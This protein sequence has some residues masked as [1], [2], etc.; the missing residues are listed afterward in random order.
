MAIA[1]TCVIVGAQASAESR[2]SHPSGGQTRVFRLT[3]SGQESVGY[4]D[5]SHQDA[6][7]CEWSE[8]GN[9][10]VYWRSSWTVTAEVYP[11]TGHVQIKDVKVLKGPD[12]NRHPGDGEAIGKRS[13]IPGSHPFC[14]Q[15]GY[16]GTYK[17]TS[18][19]VEPALFL[20]KPTFEPR[21]GGYD[22]SIPGFTFA[23]AT[24][25]G[26]APTNYPCGEHIGTDVAPGGGASGLIGGSNVEARSS[27]G[28]STLL[29][30][31]VG[32]KH[33]SKQK[34]TTHSAGWFGK[35]P[36]PGDD[37]GSGEEFSCTLTAPLQRT[38]LITLARIS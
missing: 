8:T 20:S 11:R 34:R 28:D 37:C 24:Y 4:K 29:H 5:S 15:G 18:E 33:R 6:Y 38:G 22:L 12:D 19:K 30:L 36:S 25:T 23:D 35:F 13:D 16:A 1:A 32:Q 10:T 14:S 2:G 31:G 17:C 9:A 21:A 27:V 26:Q 3:Y 7:G